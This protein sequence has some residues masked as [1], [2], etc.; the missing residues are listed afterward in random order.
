MRKKSGFINKRR[1]SS[2]SFFTK[3]VS[4]IKVIKIE[5]LFAILALIL[6]LGQYFQNSINV[7]INITETWRNGYT[8]E[9]R[10]RVSR[11]RYLYKK[12]KAD[13]KDNICQK[14]LINSIRK[15]VV[16]EELYESEIIKDD[17]ISKLI[18]D[19]IGAIKRKA[20][21][22]EATDEYVKFV[23]KKWRESCR[24][25][26]GCNEKFEDS[27]PK[28]VELNELFKDKRGTGE[29]INVIDSTNI[30]TIKQSLK[31]REP[32]RE[33]YV[34]ILLKYRNAI[35]ECLNTSES[36]KAVIESKPLPFRITIF[37]RDTLEGRYR[38]II[39]ELKIDL[40]DFIEVYR[41]STPNRETEAWYVL[42]SKE[43]YLNDLV[44]VVL[45]FLVFILVLTSVYLIKMRMQKLGYLQ[46]DEK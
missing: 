23:L 39:E 18:D 28:M 26:G 38:D 1:N 12:A 45:Y 10:D 9:I 19:E 29:L 4:V 5:L 40:M 37:Y 6:S 34:E 22:K 25:I 44:N 2:A 14:N 8:S 32:M 21:D 43:S 11:F 33:E 15:I 7:R 20:R 17:F 24:E 36:V 3:A 42:T 31:G 16:T 46:E 30:E 27:V 41:E 35:I 13:C